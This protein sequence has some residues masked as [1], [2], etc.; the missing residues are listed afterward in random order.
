MLK[1]VRVEDETCS[2]LDSDTIFRQDETTSNR[3]C[4]STEVCKIG[5][6]F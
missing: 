4:V 5:F 6:T 1:V 2:S 3:D